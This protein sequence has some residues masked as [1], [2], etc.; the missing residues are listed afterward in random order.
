MSTYRLETLLTIRERAKEAA[1]QAFAAAIQ[2]MVKEK[3][4][5]KELEEDLARRKAER[6]QKVDAYL[7][8]VLAKGVGANGLSTMNRFEDR[9]KD[10]EAQVALEIDSQKERVKVAE[11]RVETRRGEL[12]EAA[13]DLKA[14]EKHK[15]AWKKQR[16][17]EREQ[18]E[19]LAGEEI[20]SALF[21]ARSR[22]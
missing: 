21:L 6:K 18:R 10:E 7:K 14:L 12:A 1:E 9:L 8:E 3:A 13:R 22:K 4:K 20:G 16:K 11:K 17:Y 19:D 2:E 5:L 15:D